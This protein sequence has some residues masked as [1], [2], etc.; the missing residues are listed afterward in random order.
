MVLQV[1]TQNRMRRKALAL[2]L[3]LLL[4]FCLPAGG[5]KDLSGIIAPSATR[6]TREENT[7]KANTISSMLYSLGNLYAFLEDRF[8]YDIDNSKMMEDLSAAMVSS[9]GDQYSFYV[10]SSEADAY[11]E[12][13]EGSYVGLGL[14]LTKQDPRNADLDDPE[15]WMIKIESPFPGAPADRAGLRA[16][17]LVSSINGESVAPLNATEASIKLRGEEGVPVT[18]EVHRGGNTFSIT[19]TPERVTTPSSAASMLEDGTGYIA[20]YTFSMTTHESVEKNLESLLGQGAEKIIIDL[21]N[22]GGGTVESAERIAD[23]F[24]SSG[25]ILTTKFKDGRNRKDVVDRAGTTVLVDESVPL[26]VLV[27]GGT[28]SSSE[29]LTGALKDNGRAIVVGSQTFGKGVEQE[30]I[31]FGDGFVQI[32]AGH[33]YTP[34]GTDIHGVGITPDIVIEEKEY[35][36]EELDAYSE[37]LKT[38][39][40]SDFVDANPDYSHESIDRFAKENISSGVPE[41]LLQRL[42]KNEYMY[43]LD[44]T[45]RKIADPYYDEVLK[46]AME[47][48]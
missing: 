39:L 15:S 10:P 13:T 19:L 23:M 24:L 42:V 16:H 12:R 5:E 40:T 26:A 14:Y 36:D 37:F 32:T 7:E 46:A 47:A 2:A 6:P 45:E 27:N 28:A 29:I 44:Y 17:D 43:R 9:L 30:V 11:Y 18:L 8:L 41:D 3:A 25:T 4:S 34:S 35:T 22:N 38:S 1:K 21:R 48:L 31:A 33:F 20:I